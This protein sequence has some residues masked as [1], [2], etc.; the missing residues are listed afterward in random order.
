M[1]RIKKL[2]TPLVTQTLIKRVMHDRKLPSIV[3]NNFKTT[4]ENTI[5]G[6]KSDMKEDSIKLQDNKILTSWKDYKVV[7]KWYNKK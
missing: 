1:F 7:Q 4:N 5:I 3:N 6:K 2:F